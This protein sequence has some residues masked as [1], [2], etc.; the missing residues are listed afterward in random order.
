MSPALPSLNPLRRRYGVEDKN[1][2][3]PAE[4]MHRGRLRDGA[5]LVQKTLPERIDEGLFP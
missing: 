5:G 4:T 3:L 1:R 2:S